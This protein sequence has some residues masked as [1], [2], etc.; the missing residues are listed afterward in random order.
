MIFSYKIWCLIMVYCSATDNKIHKVRPCL[1][2]M[3]TYKSGDIVFYHHNDEYIPC[4][5]TFRNSEGQYK[6]S[7]LKLDDNGRIY[8]LHASKLKVKSSFFKIIH[9][10]KIFIVNAH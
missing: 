3:E 2:L 5:V 9:S 1:N 4:K 10:Y 6:V 7:S 8:Q